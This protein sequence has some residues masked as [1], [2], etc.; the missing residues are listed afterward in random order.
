[1][2]CQVDALKK[3]LTVPAVRATLSTLPPNLD[4]T[5][6]RILGNIPPEYRN[7]AQR[8]LWFLAV[9]RRPLTLRE[10]AEAVV[11]DI[12]KEVFDPE[13]RL[14]DPEV[15]LEICSSLL[16][17]SGYVIVFLLVTIVGMNC[18]LHITLYRNIS[19][20][21]ALGME[22]ARFLRLSI[23][24]S[25]NSLLEQPLLTSLHVS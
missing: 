4:A 17:L 1:M 16:T 12:E 24:S 2:E 9:S 22:H 7:E 5:Y 3:C 11:V 8:T 13:N 6:E 20:P 19:V 14:R 15:L 23:Q 10:V 21:I 18:V 25:I